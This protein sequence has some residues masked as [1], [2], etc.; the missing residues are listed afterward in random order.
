M[1][2][3]INMQIMMEQE[4]K[5]VLAV[6]LSNCDMDLRMLKSKMERLLLEQRMLLKLRADTKE[7]LSKME[8][9]TA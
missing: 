1:T 2:I 5:E 8:T 7:T 3:T 9:V 6:R 4:N